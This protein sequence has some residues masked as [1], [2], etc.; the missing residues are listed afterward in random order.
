[1]TPTMGMATANSSGRW[2]ITAPISIYLVIRYWKAPI[3]LVRRTRIVFII[4]F[5]IAVLSGC[6]QVHNTFFAPSDI[7]MY[8]RRIFGDNAES[9]TILTCIKQERYAKNE[10]SKMIIP[11]DIKER[12]RQL[13]AS[14]GGSYQVMLTCVQNEMQLRNE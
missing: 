1:M 13:S 10:L 7:E 9:G 3:S 2:L 14:T 4:A 11:P 12:C 6:T 5:V 8:C